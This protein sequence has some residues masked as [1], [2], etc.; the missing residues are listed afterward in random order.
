MN[1]YRVHR[2]TVHLNSS[3]T[4]E[5]LSSKTSV[6]LYKYLIKLAIQ[7]KKENLKHIQS[8]TESC[9]PPAILFYRRTYDPADYPCW[10]G[11]VP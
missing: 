3:S 10:T 9:A 8:F 1:K 4:R 7:P 11:G 2:F 5:S 6:I